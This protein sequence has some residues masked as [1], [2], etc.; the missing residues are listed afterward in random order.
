[1]NIF[2]RP[3]TTADSEAV[4]LVLQQAALR[5][6][7]QEMPMWRVDELTVEKLRRESGEFYLACANQKTAGVLRIQTED[8]EFWPD[9]P[10]GESIFIHRLAVLPDLAGRGVGKALLDF[11]VSKGASLNKKYL[12]LD[13][14]SD[15]P[16]LRN[17]YE[18]YGF[19]HHSDRHVGPFNVSRYEFRITPEPTVPS[20]LAIP[21]A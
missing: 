14:A 10:S 20:N 6:A 2:I 7:Q 15:R 9:V 12:R 19:I 11:A 13:C 17:I 1:M 18:T 3:A 21:S 4:S 5:L 16:K 8:P